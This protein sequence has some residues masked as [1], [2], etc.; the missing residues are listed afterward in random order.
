[1]IFQKASLE[2]E[3]QLERLAYLICLNLSTL[4]NPLTFL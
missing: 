4:E 3:Q 1:M 2:A